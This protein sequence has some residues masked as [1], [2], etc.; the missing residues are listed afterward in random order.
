[1]EAE[2]LLKLQRM[3]E[4]VKKEMKHI[5]RGDLA[6]NMFR[7][8][9]SALR[10]HGMGEKSGGNIPKEKTLV[11]AIKVV[12]KVTPD[13]LTPDTCPVFNEKEFDE[14]LL[15]RYAQDDPSVLKCIRKRFDEIK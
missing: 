12:K 14:G 6:Q 7:Q 8:A 13:T 1:M 2:G 4:Q 3:R 10:L 15:N 5:P 11:D 9:Y